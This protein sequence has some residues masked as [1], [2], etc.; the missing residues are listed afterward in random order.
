VGVWE[1]QQP[2]RWPDFPEV[3]A[4]LQAALNDL[5]ASHGREAVRCFYVCGSDHANKCGLWSSRPRKQWGGVVVV[6]RD[7]DALAGSED[8]SRCVYLAEPARDTSALSSTKV[9]QAIER[10]DFEYIR[11]ALSAAAATF[12]LQPTPEDFER[13]Q[14][15]FV[16][17]GVKAPLLPAQGMP[18]TYGG[19]ASASAMSSIGRTV[20]ISLSAL[21]RK[22]WAELSADGRL[23]SA[24][25]FFGSK[26]AWIFPTTDAARQESAAN[27]PQYL[28][29][30]QRLREC[31]LRKEEDG[32]V[33]WLKPDGLVY[34]GGLYSGDPGAY[35]RAS[36]W[37]QGLQDPATG[38]PY[39][40]LLLDP[41]W[42]RRGAAGGGFNPDSAK[43]TKHAKNIIKNMENGAHDY[44]PFC[45][46]L[47]QSNPSL[48]P[49]FT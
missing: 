27:N 9:R 43:Y 35:S 46:L 11:V 40:P 33:F 42:W 37:L 14:S 18:S 22:P 5:A 48:T 31:I 28:K 32:L 23:P 10:G 44:D 24:L 1:A 49:A 21:L 47:V 17:L 2:G 4:A 3:C 39:R 36:K 16:K 30:D 13:F 29:M 34:D 45:E 41:S 6:P 38:A 26:R 8:V 7:G 12:L 20:F 15:D 25:F 19:T